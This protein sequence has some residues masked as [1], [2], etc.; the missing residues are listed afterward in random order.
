MEM[1][2]DEHMMKELFLGELA[3]MNLSQKDT[4]L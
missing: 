4:N 1:T 3:N 2:R